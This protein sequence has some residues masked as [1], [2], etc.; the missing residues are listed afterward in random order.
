MSGD[1]RDI[2]YLSEVVTFKCRK[3]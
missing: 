3:L 1:I 2:N